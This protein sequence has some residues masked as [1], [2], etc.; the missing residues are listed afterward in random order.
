MV[1][2]TGKFET[3][4][5]R[6]PHLCHTSP[7]E[8]VALLKA[9]NPINSYKELVRNRQYIEERAVYHEDDIFHDEPPI[10]TIYIDH[11]QEH[12][13]ALDAWIKEKKFQGYEIFAELT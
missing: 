12:I 6:A 11:G 7:S 5:E 9:K 8:A 10:Q 3:Q 13:A 2:S 1:M 4:V